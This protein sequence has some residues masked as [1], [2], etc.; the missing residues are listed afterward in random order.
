MKKSQI[1]MLNNFKFKHIEKLY[2]KRLIFSK[3][4]SQT[5]LFY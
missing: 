5:I 4:I 1:S 2:L 3:E